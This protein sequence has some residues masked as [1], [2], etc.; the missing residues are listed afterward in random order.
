IGPVR[1]LD[2]VRDRAAICDGLGVRDRLR[3]CMERIVVD[4]GRRPRELIRRRGLSDAL[5]KTVRVICHRGLDPG[6]RT[7]LVANRRQ[8]VSGPGEDHPLERR[9]S[10]VYLDLVYSIYNPLVPVV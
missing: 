2:D 4:E 9:E 10:A 7:R 5:E 3:I 6:L 8:L 1:L